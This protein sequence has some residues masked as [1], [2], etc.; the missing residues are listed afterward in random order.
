MVFT[1][2]SLHWAA[3]L[4]FQ[5]VVDSPASSGGVKRPSTSEPPVPEKRARHSTGAGSD[6]RC[7][8]CMQQS[9]WVCASECACVCVWGGGGCKIRV[10]GLERT[11]EN[12][13]STGVCV[14]PDWTTLNLFCDRE[15]SDSSCKSHLLIFLIIYKGC[16]CKTKSQKNKRKNKH[17]LCRNSLKEFKKYILWEDG[18]GR[19]CMHGVYKPQLILFPVCFHCHVSAC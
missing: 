8:P 16:W 4:S 18:V 13:L 15:M 10:Q 14:C 19:L 2:L 12:E 7:N 5:A 1:P 3:S 17:A 6:V 11:V 9:V